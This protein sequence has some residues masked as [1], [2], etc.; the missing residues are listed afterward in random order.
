MKK[1]VIASIFIIVILSIILYYNKCNATQKDLLTKN[2]IFDIIED[3]ENIVIS[4]ITKSGNKSMS[5]QDKLDFAV[6]YI[7]DNRQKYNSYIINEQ[8]PTY[9]NKENIVLGK[10]EIDFFNS[11]LEKF[12]SDVNYS[13]ENYKFYKEGFIELN[14]EPVENTCWDDKECIK[15]QEEENK[16]HIYIKYIKLFNDIKN[17]FYVEYIFDV[18]EQIKIDEVTIYNSTMN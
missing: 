17:E 7:I 4:C 16:Y 18:N 10:V 5:E 11:I 9:Y 15:M 1:Y 8:I 14:S 6:R 13:L 3:V 2:I 12:F